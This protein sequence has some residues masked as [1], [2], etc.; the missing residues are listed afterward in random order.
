[1]PKLPSKVIP[2]YQ[3]YNEDCFETFKRIK[4]GSI[5]LILCDP[6]YG[7]TQADWDS[8]IPLEPMWK[9]LARIIKPNGAIILTSTQPFTTSLINSGFWLFKY[10][11]VWIK[12]KASSFLNAHHKPMSMHEDILLFSKGSITRDKKT[13]YAITYKPQGLITL[14]E[15]VDGRKE[16]LNRGRGGHN[17][18]KSNA[19]LQEEYLQTHTNWPTS[20][21]KLNSEGK[22]THP[23]QKP[24]ALMEYLIK[25]YSYKNETVLDFA[26]GSG[27]TGVAC[28]NLGR[29]FIGCDNDTTFGYFQIAEKR[30]REAYVNKSNT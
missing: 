23:T 21:I 30:I 17:F 9:E 5:D 4:D 8:I 2:R 13:G 1:M 22:T 27:T 12:S 16:Q 14:G 20:V 28:G 25:T 15:V 10:A 26:F 19:G 24:V 7:T 29:K 18:Q 6:P 11:M 3:I